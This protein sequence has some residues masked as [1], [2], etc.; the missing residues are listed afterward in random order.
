MQEYA[1]PTIWPLKFLSASVVSTVKKTSGCRII[2]YY[3]HVHNFHF[4]V[5]SSFVKFV[6]VSCFLFP[7]DLVSS[8]YVPFPR[9]L[10]VPVVFSLIQSNT[11]L[12][13]ASA[14]SVSGRFSMTSHFLACATLKWLRE[15]VC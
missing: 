14:L 2:T 9:E 1:A 12:C 3:S 11:L 15:E 13:S 4:C 7:F 5:S 8:V 10:P 6:C